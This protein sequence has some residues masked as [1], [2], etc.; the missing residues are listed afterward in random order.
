[1]RAELAR[2][3]SAAEERDTDAM[4][5]LKRCELADAS[6]RSAEEAAERRLAQA[7][8]GAEVEMAAAERAAA[9]REAIAKL[10]GED[11]MR[12]ERA[13]SEAREAELRRGMEKLQV[14]IRRMANEA[15]KSDETRLALVQ[16]AELASAERNALQRECVSL[17]MESSAA[18]ERADMLQQTLN[19]RTQFAGEL[20]VAAEERERTLRKH[21]AEAAASAKAAAAA[22]LEEERARGA[23]DAR[24]LRER[25]DLANDHVAR[26][27]VR[28]LP[29][30]PAAWL[31]TPPESA[32]HWSELWTAK[33]WT[34][35]RGAGG[36][37][38]AAAGPD[39]RTHPRCA[40]RRASSRS[41]PT[42]GAD[43]CT[44]SRRRTESVRKRRRTR[45]LVSRCRRQRS[46]THT[47]LW[48]RRC[49]HI[50]PPQRPCQ[51]P[52]G[53]TRRWTPHSRPHARR[54]P[55]DAPHFS[56]QRPRH[57]RRAW[58]TA[59]GSQ[60][61]TP[62][63]LRCAAARICLLPAGST[64]RLRRH[65]PRITLPPATTRTIPSFL[66]LRARAWM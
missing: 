47:R 64:I 66:R 5:L 61:P 38:A 34:R 49:R 21:Y 44:P 33:L 40:P 4:R 18:R 62:R 2:A 35:G 8:E 28:S 1:M 55:R 43:T 32:V 16:K 30:P 15:A 25:L 11:E 19:Q 23:A 53:S 59:A 12:A 51:Q 39:L 58:T 56:P 52:P 37:A 13:R 22:A 14:Q 46:H 36:N 17:R 10:A 54:S 63:A 41:T 48:C 3:V 65:L 9:E 20:Q 60:S 31:R 29:Y 6:A 57:T 7:R 50:R 24:E 42:R 27:Q 26:L 45:C